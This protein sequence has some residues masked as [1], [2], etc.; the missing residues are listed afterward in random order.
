MEARGST[1]FLSTFTFLIP[2]GLVLTLKNLPPENAQYPMSNF[3]GSSHPEDS[4]SE[5]VVQHPVI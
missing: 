2:K 4:W 1:F 3:G 5:Q